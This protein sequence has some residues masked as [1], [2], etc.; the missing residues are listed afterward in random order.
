VTT[1]FGVL[2]NPARRRLF[3]FR[4]HGAPVAECVPLITESHDVLDMDANKKRSC[5]ASPSLTGTYTTIVVLDQGLTVLLNTAST[6][7]C[8]LGQT[9]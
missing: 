3:R 4:W 5:L 2:E 1:F 6:Q 8:Q 7:S 9:R